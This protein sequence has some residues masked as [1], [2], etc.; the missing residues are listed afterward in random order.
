[1]RFSR[2]LAAV[3]NLLVD[4]QGNTIATTDS[5][6]NRAAICEALGFRESTVADSKAVLDWATEHVVLQEWDVERITAAV[7]VLP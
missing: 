2:D 5:S 6:G 3:L 4:G 7:V 1:M